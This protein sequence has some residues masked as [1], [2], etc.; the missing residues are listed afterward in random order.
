MTADGNNVY[1]TNTHLQ[2]PQGWCLK[3]V[4]EVFEFGQKNVA[5]TELLKKRAICGF[6]CVQTLSLP[7]VVCHGWKLHKSLKFCSSVSSLRLTFRVI[8]LSDSEL[9]DKHRLQSLEEI[10]PKTGFQLPACHRFPCQPN[11]LMPR[12]VTPVPPVDDLGLWLAVAEGGGGVTSDAG[13]RSGFAPRCSTQLMFQFQSPHPT[14]PPSPS[15]FFL[16]RALQ[17]DLHPLRG[18]CVPVQPLQPCC[19]LGRVTKPEWGFWLKTWQNLLAPSRPT[20][21][22]H[23]CITGKN[24]SLTQRERKTG[25]N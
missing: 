6:E 16:P 17:P 15:L 10:K 20:Q 22:S 9:L 2:S 25:G 24:K 18:P 8:P 7:R 23:A 14:P 19:R 3:Q 21:V 4:V 5:P 12:R 11:P 13:C 1:F